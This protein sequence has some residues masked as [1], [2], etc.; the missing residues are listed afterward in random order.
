M[1]PRGFRS[2]R[3][4]KKWL[5]GSLCLAAWAAY[6]DVIP[7]LPPAGAPQAPVAETNWMDHFHRFVHDTLQENVERGDHWFVPE[8]VNPQTVPPTR[9]RLG[10][11]GQLNLRSGNGF[12][13]APMLDTSVDIKVPDIESR[14]KLF[15]TTIDPTRLPGVDTV[16]ADN[17]LRAGLSRLWWDQFDTSVGVKVRWLPEVYGHAGWA[18]IYTNGLWKFYPQAKGYWESSDGFGEIT[19]FTCFYHGRNPK[20]GQEDGREDRE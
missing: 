9:L 14:L 10:L 20:N 8:G 1:T 13:L 2:R 3:G 11:Y 4:P 15:L 6:A 18:P 19:S 16:N 12:Q 5:L 17:A 7:T